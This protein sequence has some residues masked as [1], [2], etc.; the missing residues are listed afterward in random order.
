M[1][2]SDEIEADYPNS[3]DVTTV[4]AVDPFSVKSTQE[5]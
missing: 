5:G 1:S 2:L 3:W 4:T